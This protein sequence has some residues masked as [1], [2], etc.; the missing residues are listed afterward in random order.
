M[1]WD[2]SYRLSAALICF[3]H[4]APRYAQPYA[5]LHRGTKKIDAKHRRRTSPKRPIVCKCDNKVSNE[6]LRPMKNFLKSIELTNN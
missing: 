4:V 5:I 1:Q 3:P 2:Y 6:Q